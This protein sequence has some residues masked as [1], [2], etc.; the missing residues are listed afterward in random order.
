MWVRGQLTSVRGRVRVR[1]RC[2]LGAGI[3]GVKEPSHPVT[4]SLR[5]SVI[6]I[7][8]PVTHPQN[9]NAHGY[10][11]TC[12]ASF[13]CCSSSSRRRLMAPLPARIGTRVA[14]C[15]DVDGRLL[16]AS[17][18]A[19]ASTRSTPVASRTRFRVDVEEVFAAAAASLSF[20]SPRMRASRF[21][22]SP[23]TLA[24]ARAKERPLWFW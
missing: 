21:S 22:V 2:V 7:H 10:A 19:S 9:P 6:R 20:G 5:H 15:P 11:V 16:S 23:I 18:S 1:V 3:I 24:K 4:P 13:S 14:G 17:A 8:T 12:S